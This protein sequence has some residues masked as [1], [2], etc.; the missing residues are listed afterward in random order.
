VDPAA[1]C[2]LL[3]ALGEALARA[4]ST[5]EAKQTFLTAADLARTSRLPEHLSWAALGYGGRFPWLRAGSDS[6]LV[7]LCPC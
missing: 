1:H 2:E 3:L 6:R 7:P 4:G 5:P